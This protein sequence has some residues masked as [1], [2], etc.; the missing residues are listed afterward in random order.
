MYLMWNT[1]YADV[2]GKM[3]I[4]FYFIQLFTVGNIDGNQVST[5]IISYK[6]LSASLP[7]AMCLTETAVGHD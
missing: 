2:M 6:S 3:Y 4:R 7:N 5:S 1:L